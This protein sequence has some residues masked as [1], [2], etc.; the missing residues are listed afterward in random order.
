MIQ[1][2]TSNDGSGLTL[3]MKVSVYEVRVA[4]SL[5]MS[6]L[7]SMEE[8]VKSIRYTMPQLLGSALPTGC[9]IMNVPNEVTSQ[10]TKSC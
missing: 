9:T 7:N 6:D 10:Q 5:L 2:K 4:N 8:K 1:H 3:D